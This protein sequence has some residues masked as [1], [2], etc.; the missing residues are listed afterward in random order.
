MRKWFNRLHNN[1]PL[2]KLLSRIFAALIVPLCLL[3]VMDLQY[4]GLHFPVWLYVTLG[5][6]TFL[7]LLLFMLLRFTEPKTEPLTLED[8]E[9]EQLRKAA[10]DKETSEDWQMAQEAEEHIFNLFR[11][12]GISVEHLRASP[13]AEDMGGRAYTF[14]KPLVLTPTE[15]EQLPKNRVLTVDSSLQGDK[16]IVT[17]FEISSMTLHTYARFF[18][19]PNDSK[20]K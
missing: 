5:L 19:D 14:E 16:I 2:Q 3:F 9:A 8:L 10:W 20:N 12:N 11:N 1:Y 6:P 4:Q 13:M 7:L 18:V 17:G 15:F